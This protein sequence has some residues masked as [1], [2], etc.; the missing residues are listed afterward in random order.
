MSR[1]K[2]KWVSNLLGGMDL[3]RKVG[4]LM[5]FSFAG[6]VIT[7]DVVELIT[8]YHLGG[9]RV[10]LKF[11]TT[12][13]T[14]DVKPGTTPNEN[15]LRSLAYPS[16]LNRDFAD[17]KQCV[18]CTPREYAEVLNRL[19]DCA[20]AR[21]GGVPIHFTI[22]QEGNG[23]DDLIC[24]QR[25]FPCPMGFAAA[26]EPALAY[27]A[28]VSIGRQAR[29]VGINMI[30]SPVLDVNTNPRNPE[31][32]TRAYS[33]RTDVV[34]RYALE[35]LRGFQE[36]G[37]IAT[38]KHFP[39]RGESVADAHWSLPSVTADLSTLREQHIAP[40]HEMIAA[41]LPAVMTAQCCYPALGCHD[42][43]ATTS[44][45]IVTDLLR[46]E[47]G[48]AGVITTDNMTMGGIVQRYDMREACVLALLAGCDLVLC[49]DESPNRVRIIEAIIEA[50]RGGRIKESRIDASVQ[51]V[52]GMRWEMGL[53]ENGGKVDAARAADPIDDPFVVKAT[54]EA[55]DKSILLLRDEAKVLPLRPERK[56]LLVEQVFPTH[57]MANNI[58]CHPGLLWEEMCKLSPNVG[59]VEVP[60]LPGPAD[61][62]RVLRRVHEAEVIVATNYYYHKA[63]AT[64]TDLVRQLH[65]FCK[66]V[67][68][69]TNTPYDRAAPKDFPTVVTVFTA[70]REN[71]RAAVEVIYGKLKPTA[72]MPVKV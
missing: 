7:P 53:A 21:P 55:A 59:S 70:G 52:L 47:L 17:P 41:G 13:L 51:R 24:G 19:R 45:E 27:R 15:V 40:Y 48:F 6:P 9:L 23:S 64:M 38:G 54:N 29:A 4:Q 28:A 20:L 61:H 36:T 18:N 32:G 63:A 44:R 37:L 16:G 26:D 43:P 57:Q 30:H 69:I 50:V 31:I 49:R 10:S 3:E 34:T 12:T 42:A 62:Q 60:I 72:K 66:P 11:R 46:G 33:D 65:G 8:R 71:L 1:A 56:V 2:E 39:G 58:S 25:L 14:H 5:V 67:I 35:S 68:V 22:D